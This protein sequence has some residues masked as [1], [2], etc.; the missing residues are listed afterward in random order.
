MK[1]YDIKMC[2]K[3]YRIMVLSEE[4]LAYKQRDVE[5]LKFNIDIFNTNCKERNKFILLKPPYPHPGIVRYVEC[6]Y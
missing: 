5:Y 1:K 6:E 3:T 2:A 4:I